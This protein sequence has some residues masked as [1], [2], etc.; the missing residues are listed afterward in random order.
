ML[1]WKV[2]EFNQLTVD[3]LYELVQLR[4]EV[5]VVEQACVYQ[6]LDDKDQIAFHLLGYKD[7]KLQAYSR[8]F[9]SGTLYEDA[10]IGRVIVRESERAK[11][12][13]QELLEHAISLIT[14]EF[15]DDSIL[16]HAQ[17]YLTYFYQSFGFQPVSDIYL[18]DG[19]NHLDM[20][21]WRGKNE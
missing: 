20:R 15:H 7:G 1:N 2:K 18:L 8:L 4:I 10:S 12:Y 19:I 21:R 5:F 16:I 14:N 9:K 6:E 17:E 11:G 13:G 3:E